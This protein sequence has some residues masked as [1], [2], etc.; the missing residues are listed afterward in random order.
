MQDKT[1]MA[2]EALRA[3][4]NVAEE[5]ITHWNPTEVDRQRAV[6]M[7][8]VAKGQIFAALEAIEEQ[9]KTG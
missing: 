3:G 1:R 7:L 8:Q 2:L 5:A 6:G 9:L 4:L